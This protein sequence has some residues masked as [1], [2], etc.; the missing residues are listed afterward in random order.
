MGIIEH[1][2]I[3]RNLG[4]GLE[5]FIMIQKKLACQTKTYFHQ[6]RNTIDRSEKLK[7]HFPTKKD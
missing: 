6:R 7:H 3:R 5:F 1:G 2:R 4:A